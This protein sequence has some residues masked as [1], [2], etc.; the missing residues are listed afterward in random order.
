MRIKLLDSKRQLDIQQNFHLPYLAAKV[1][2][3]KQLCDEEIKELLASPILSDPF[4]AKGIQE[5]ADRIYLAK[6]RKEKVLVCGD[7]DADGICATAIMVDALQR[8]GMNAGFYIPNRFK[9]GYGLQV[10]TVEM[11]KKKVIPY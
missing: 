2:A 11:A 7:Y 1:L 3:S 4:K 6:Q 9:E 10:H 8:Y 5:A